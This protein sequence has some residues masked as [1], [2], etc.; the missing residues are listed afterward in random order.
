MGDDV[1]NTCIWRWDGRRIT[2]AW[3]AGREYISLLAA[4]RT[5]YKVAI[6]DGLTGHRR[7]QPD[8]HVLAQFGEISSYAS[9]G[10]SANE[11]GPQYFHAQNPVA[12]AGDVWYYQKERAERKNLKSVLRRLKDRVVQYIR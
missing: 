4:A 1:S 5:P 10:L 2:L 6:S 7:L 11:K 12:A 9:S 8:R 3:R